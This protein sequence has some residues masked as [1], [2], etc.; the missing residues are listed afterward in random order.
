MNKIPKHG[1]FVVVWWWANKPWSAT[2]QWSEGKLELYDTVLGF[3]DNNCPAPADL[4]RH[5]DKYN[6]KIIHTG[7]IQSW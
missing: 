4:Q 6:A 1:Q 7:D 5:I 2:Y 3:F